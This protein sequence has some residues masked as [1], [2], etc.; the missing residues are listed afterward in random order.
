VL[1]LLELV[2]HNIFVS[3]IGSGMAMFR[4]K[5][6]FNILLFRWRWQSEFTLS[7][8]LMVL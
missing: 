8:R 2:L 6:D 3:G 1:S 4:G 7:K 5:Q